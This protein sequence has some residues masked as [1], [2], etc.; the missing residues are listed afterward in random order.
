[1]HSLHSVNP[2][3]RVIPE[4]DARISGAG[5]FGAKSVMVHIDGSSR[6]P[7]RLPG[8]GILTHIHG[9]ISTTIQQNAACMSGCAGQVL[10]P[11]PPK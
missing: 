7:A 11:R 4:C 9:D 8:F 6:F 1:M 2:L 3:E 10:P 5:S